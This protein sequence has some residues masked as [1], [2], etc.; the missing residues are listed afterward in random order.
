MFIL[1]TTR[2]AIDVGNDEHDVARKA[3]ADELYS[4]I[5]VHVSELFGVRFKLYDFNK[6]FEHHANAAGAV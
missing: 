1:V 5:L 4:A 2:P 6:M 3:Y